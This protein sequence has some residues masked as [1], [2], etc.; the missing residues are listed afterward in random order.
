MGPG[1]LSGMIQMASC[2]GQGFLVTLVTV[3]IG[4]AALGERDASPVTGTVESV[5]QEGVGVVPERPS[6]FSTSGSSSF[7]PFSAALSSLRPEERAEVNQTGVS[8]FAKVCEPRD[9][10]VVC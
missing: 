2:Q 6:L 5:G 4:A 7:N 8:C 3:C 10:E 1:D 9:A